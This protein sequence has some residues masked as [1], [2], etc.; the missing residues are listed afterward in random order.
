M[1]SAGELSHDI[2]MTNLQK[3]QTLSNRDKTRQDRQDH[4]HPWFFHFF[5]TF[6]WFRNFHN[7]PSPLGQWLKPWWL[8]Q[9]RLRQDLGLFGPGLPLDV[10]QPLAWRPDPDPGAN[11]RAGHADPR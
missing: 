1:E 4:H 3:G 8:P 6:F 2:P 9:D 10:V 5:F 11:S 7:F